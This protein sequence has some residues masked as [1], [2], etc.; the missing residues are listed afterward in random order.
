MFNQNNALDLFR[1]DRFVSD[2][3]IT[4]TISAMVWILVVVEL[5]NLPL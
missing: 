2:A 3:V 1:K 5:F 4:F